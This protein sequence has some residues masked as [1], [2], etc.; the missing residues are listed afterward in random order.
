MRAR[1][2]MLLSDVAGHEVEQLI[3]WAHAL[4]LREQYIKAFIA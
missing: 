2:A 3:S 4:R 1:R